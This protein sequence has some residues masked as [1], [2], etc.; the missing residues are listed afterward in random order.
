[1]K[2]KTFRSTHSDKFDLRFDYLIMRKI[3]YENPDQAQL[4]TTL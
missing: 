1:M 4:R 3:I 2:N